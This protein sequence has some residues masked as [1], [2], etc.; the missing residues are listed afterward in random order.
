MHKIDGG[1]VKRGAILRVERA[2]GD[3]PGGLLH[4]RGFAKARFLLNL[5]STGVGYPVKP[6]FI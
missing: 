6:R 2:I 5:N 1:C 4:R 3:V